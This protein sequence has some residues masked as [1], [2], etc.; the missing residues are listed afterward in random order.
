MNQNL[1]HNPK[2]PPKGGGFQPQTLM[3]NTTLTLTLTLFLSL[4]CLAGPN[5]VT[6]SP[7]TT[8]LPSLLPDPSI[9]PTLTGSNAFTGTNVFSGFN[10][11]A[12]TFTGNSFGQFNGSGT[13]SNALSAATAIVA[14]TATIAVAATAAATAN[15]AA[16]AGNLTTISTNSINTNN[17]SQLSSG[18]VPS[19]VLSGSSITNASGFFFP[20]TGTPTL[21]PTCFFPIDYNGTFD[22][23]TAFLPTVGGVQIGFG[24]QLIQG[25]GS[26]KAYWDVL[27]WPQFQWSGYTNQL[28][29]VHIWVQT[30]STIAWV[31]NVRYMTNGLTSG[32]GLGVQD[33][34]FAAGVINCTVGTNDYWI[35]ATNNWIPSQMTNVQAALFYLGT[36]GISSNC[37]IIQGSSIKAQ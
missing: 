14:G 28:F 2:S 12:G 23:A 25:T 7:W 22:Q 13:I 16:T 21:P 19:S 3:N 18:T 36:G 24:K 37:W 29:S 27:N 15:V 1:H 32:G 8:N 9:V 31:A 26:P 6:Q 5:P 11:F 34:Q 10:A 33:K 30:N 4:N 17:A 20:P 35:T